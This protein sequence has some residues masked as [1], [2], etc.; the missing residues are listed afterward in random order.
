[1]ETQSTEMNTAL[2][3]LNPRAG[4]GKA[5]QL[6]S[7]VEAALRATHIQ[8]ITVETKAP[9]E[10]T[11]IAA[12][13]QRSK[14]FN[15]V[16]AGGGDGLLNE[17]VTGLA[18]AAARN[19]ELVPIGILPFGTANDFWTTLFGASANRKETHW[20]MA[21]EAIARNVIAQ[22][23]LGSVVSAIPLVSYDE[24]SRHFFTN[25]CGA[26]FVAQAATRW[27]ALRKNPL[28]PLRNYTVAGV[29]AALHR[30]RSFVDVRF[31]ATSEVE[32]QLDIVSCMNGGKFGGFRLAASSLTDGKF[33]VLTAQPMSG[34][35]ILQLLWKVLHGRSIHHPKVRFR[36]ARRFVITSDQG[37]FAAELDGEVR[38]LRTPAVVENL[39]GRLRVIADASSW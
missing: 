35:E 15:T 28:R 34:I 2:L 7:A 12:S 33:E 8:L 9:G 27:T 39:P 3:I 29:L 38:V 26:G 23:D 1:L 18:R 37:F 13:A 6:R 10:A 24:A 5:R 20:Q 21:V 16:L 17:V 14:L 36:E 31:D 22:V 30:R 19:E 11:S 25:T 4:N 32:S